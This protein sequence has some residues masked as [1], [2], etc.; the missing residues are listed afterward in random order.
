MIQVD[1]VANLAQCNIC[2]HACFLAES[3]QEN[4]IPTVDWPR[5]S[6]VDSPR[7]TGIG[8]GYILKSSQLS[9]RMGIWRAQEQDHVK[10]YLAVGAFWSCIAAELL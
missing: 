10:H 2:W 6:M 7:S 8:V 9:D 3:L 1:L 4:Q 5:M